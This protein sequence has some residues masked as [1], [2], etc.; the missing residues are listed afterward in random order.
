MPE[1]DPILTLQ[2]HNKNT[3][4]EK[5]VRF[6]SLFRPLFDHFLSF[7]VQKSPVAPKRMAKMTRKVV[8]FTTFLTFLVNYLVQL[9]IKLPYW[10]KVVK[11]VKLDEKRDTGMP[12]QA[13]LAR[14]ALP[15]LPVHPI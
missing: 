3:L 9:A 4:D 1:N 2:K 8:I 15:G 10:Q 12:G 13:S 6:L 14:H 11:L 5:V 7:L